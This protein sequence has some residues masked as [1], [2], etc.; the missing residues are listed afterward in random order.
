MHV[1]RE[2]PR[3]LLSRYT[4]KYVALLHPIT[5]DKETMSYYPAPFSLEQTAAWIERSI[6][7]YEE[8][9]FGRYGVFLKDTLEFIGCVG[10]FRTEVNGE[11]END[12]GY[13]LGKPYWHHGYATEAAQACIDMA[14][15]NAW[16][17]RIV[18]QMAVEHTASRQVAGRLGAKLESQFI[19]HRNRGK[20]TNLFV[21]DI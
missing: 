19:K 7:C 17:S 2:T 21:L 13:I 4:L 3:L 15:E 1:V 14:K 6:K 10:F 20:L 5:S 18:I 9:G 11:E 16:F 12:L 8:F